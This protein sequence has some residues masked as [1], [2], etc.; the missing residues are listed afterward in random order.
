MLVR[1]ILST[2]D[3]RWRI[4]P[5]SS[6]PAL[7]WVTFWATVRMRNGKNN[8]NKVAL[9]APSISWAVSTGTGWCRAN[10]VSYSNGY[11]HCTGA[12]TIIGVILT[13][14]NDISDW[15]AQSYNANCLSAPS[16]S[17]GRF[18]RSIRMYKVDDTCTSKWW[19]GK[20]EGSFCVKPMKNDVGKFVHPLNLLNSRLWSLRNGILTS[21]GAHLPQLIL[22][23]ARVVW[24]KVYFWKVQAAIFIKQ[25]LHFPVLELIRR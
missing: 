5:T 19:L 25:K 4:T 2:K 22:F 24:W 21:Q 14:S 6:I 3:F 8:T 18:Y 15:S 1:A 17:F 20:F 7:L 10:A 9:A 13:K 16:F 23:H 11:V 12:G